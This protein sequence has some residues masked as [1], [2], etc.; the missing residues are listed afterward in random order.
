MMNTVS[1]IMGRRHPYI[2][3]WVVKHWF[4]A[5]FATQGRTSLR[6]LIC[7]NWISG[8]IFNFIKVLGLDVGEAHYISIW[9]QS[10]THS[11]KPDQNFRCKFFDSVGNGTR[12]YGWVLQ[13]KEYLSEPLSYLATN[14][15]RGLAEPY[16]REKGERKRNSFA[17]NNPSIKQN[18]EYRKKPPSCRIFFLWVL[19]TLLLPLKQ[20]ELPDKQLI[21]N[22]TLE[23][24]Y[25]IF[26]LDLIRKLMGAINKTFRPC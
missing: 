1:L 19:S 11:L 8:K 4:T 9:S 3:C 20:F 13:K 14:G 6:N 12:F 15:S 16:G 17:Y 7:R 23:C 2:F 22:R 21:A 24:L 18:S 5:G 26:Y 25:S 10:K